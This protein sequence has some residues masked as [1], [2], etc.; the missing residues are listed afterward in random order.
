MLPQKKNLLRRNAWYRQQLLQQAP[1]SATS[2]VDSDRTYHVSNA[3]GMSAS[4]TG[5]SPIQTESG[6]AY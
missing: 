2:G 3:N 5:K 1:A 6:V 4:T